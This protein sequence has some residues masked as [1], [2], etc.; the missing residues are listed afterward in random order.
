MRHY[1]LSLELKIYADYLG[2]L[3]I[4]PRIL[5][6]E[7]TQTDY[8]WNVYMTIADHYKA[9]IQSLNENKLRKY[10]T[11][12]YKAFNIELKELV[13]KIDGTKYAINKAFKEYKQINDSF[14]SGEL[15]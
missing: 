1:P 7:I 8:P 5:N 13:V 3:Q 9:Y 11:D 12:I 6:A 15:K 14:P 4:H 2:D 10:F